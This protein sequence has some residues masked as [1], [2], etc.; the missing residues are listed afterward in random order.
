MAF[1]EA[2]PQDS[3]CPGKVKIAHFALQLAR[4]PEHFRFLSISSL[5][6]SLL[7]PMEFPP[8]PALEIRLV[9]VKVNDCESRR[10]GSQNIAVKN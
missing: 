5:L 6:I 4:F 10:C 1:S 9:W 7:L 8:L 2:L 3:V